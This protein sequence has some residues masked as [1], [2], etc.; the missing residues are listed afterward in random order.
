MGADGAGGGKGGGTPRDGLAGFLMAKGL[1]GNT[2][3]IKRRPYHF[4]FSSDP[5]SHPVYV[6]LLTPFCPRHVVSD[7]AT[8]NFD[9]KLVER[10]RKEFSFHSHPREN[11]LALIDH[12]LLGLELPSKNRAELFS[13]VRA[14]EQSNHIA[15]NMNT[16][17]IISN[18]FLVELTNRARKI[19]F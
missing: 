10:V 2:T 8:Q 19:R 1:R 16:N 14:V 17:F 13:Q 9:R 3:A 12:I 5:H 4:V 6:S 7:C 11:R 15:I 18:N